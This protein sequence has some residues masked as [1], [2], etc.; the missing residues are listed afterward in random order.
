M[1]IAAPSHNHDPLDEFEVTAPTRTAPGTQRDAEAPPA[2]AAVHNT[3]GRY[4]LIAPIGAGAMGLVMSAYDPELG[5]K[6]AI[7]LLKATGD[8]QRARARIEREAKAIAMIDHPNV[9]S[10]YDV[11]VDEGQLFVAM[12]Y[13]Q[14]V[15]LRQWLR[16]PGDRG[17]RQIVEVFEQAGRGLAAAHA[18]GLVHRDFKPENVMLREDGRPV[19]MDFGLARSLAESERADDDR[20][21]SEPADMTGAGAV[22]TPA[23]MS[24]KPQNPLN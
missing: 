3:I 5:R 22:G 17:W 6:V 16:A 9:V 15:T 13:I 21:A 18:G 2:E 7:K 23:Y 20:A 4:V 12:E 10:V 14:G 1:L 24:P 11:G 8:P 19:V